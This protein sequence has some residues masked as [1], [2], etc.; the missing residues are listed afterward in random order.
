[1][2]LG[3][4]MKIYLVPNFLT[5]KTKEELVKRMLLK[6]IEDNTHYNFFDIQKDG[7]NWVAWYLKEVDPYDFAKND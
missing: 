3:D 6:N 2:P 1:M 5:A 7:S 4:K